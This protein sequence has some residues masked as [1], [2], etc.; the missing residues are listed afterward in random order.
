MES[1]NTNTKRTVGCTDTRREDRVFPEQ[2]T[3]RTRTAESARTEKKTSPG[4]PTTH[5][6]THFALDR[7]G[8]GGPPQ[9]SQ[10]DSTRK[11]TKYV[12][13]RL[14]RRERERVTRF[15]FAPNLKF[16]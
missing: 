6:L 10:I 3:V 14:F 16:D 7:S 2:H 15:L 11:S 9:W 4:A 5:P 13:R 1:S 12:C 8:P